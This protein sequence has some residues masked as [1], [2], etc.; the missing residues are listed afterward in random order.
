VLLVGAGAL[1]TEAV[2]EASGV[3]TVN[4]RPAAVKLLD[5]MSIIPMSMRVLT[6]LNC[7]LFLWYKKKMRKF[8]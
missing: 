3:R 6:V 7:I 2:I 8:Y 4:W 5:G 1:F